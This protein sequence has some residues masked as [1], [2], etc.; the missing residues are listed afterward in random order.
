MSDWVIARGHLVKNKV[1]IKRPITKQQPRTDIR[2]GN[3]WDTAHYRLIVEPVECLF[4]SILGISLECAGKNRIYARYIIQRHS[5]VF[6]LPVKVVLSQ[7]Q[8][9]QK[10]EQFRH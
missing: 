8:D 3:G 2:N 6:G 7:S 10:A 4:E 1:G 9:L 5:P